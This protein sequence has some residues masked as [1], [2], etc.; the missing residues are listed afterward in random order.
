MLEVGAKVIFRDKPYSYFSDYE[1]VI[2]TVKISYLNSQGT[3]NIML[4]E[5]DRP[6]LVDAKLLEVV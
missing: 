5:L 2:F 3:N 4:E 6:H 1:G